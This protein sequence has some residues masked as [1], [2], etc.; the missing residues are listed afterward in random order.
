M[1][2][3]ETSDEECV[4]WEL[5]ARATIGFDSAV[6]SLQERNNLLMEW[7]RLGPSPKSALGLLRDRA[8]LITALSE[9]RAHALEDAIIIGRLSSGAE[10]QSLMRLNNDLVAREATARKEEREACAKIADPTGK[11]SS[12]MPVSIAAAIRAR[13]RS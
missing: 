6:L 10:L 7:M 2:D 1:I 11:H 12:D 4:D 9:A 8:R 13:S 3:L 5:A